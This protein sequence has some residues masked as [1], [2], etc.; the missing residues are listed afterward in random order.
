V[1][2][3]PEDGQEGQGS[4]KA[5]QGVLTARRRVRS[6]AGSFVILNF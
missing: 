3:S 5:S 6:P 4:Q 1:E 2:A